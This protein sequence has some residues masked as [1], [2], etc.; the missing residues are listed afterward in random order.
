MHE[1]I[2]RRMWVW[3]APYG[4]SA[5]IFMGFYMLA[6]GTARVIFGSSLVGGVAIFPAKVYG[7]IMLAG[8][9]CLLLTVPPRY[10]YRW[11]GRIVAIGCALI[12]LL[13]IGQAWGSWI[14]ISGA[15]IFVLALVN[16]VRANA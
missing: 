15:F 6:Q 2:A 4:T 11:P 14:S 13:I 10:R 16:E 5:R 12:W 7:A 8:G 1:S 9:L 3:F